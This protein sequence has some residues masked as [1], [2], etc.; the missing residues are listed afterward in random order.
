[1]VAAQGDMTRFVLD[2][3]TMWQVNKRALGFPTEPRMVF[4]ARAMRAFAA[5]HF[6]L[7]VHCCADNLPAT[8]DASASPSQQPEARPSAPSSS[9]RT[10]TIG[11]Q[12]VVVIPSGG[13]ASG[14]G[15]FLD[16]SCS[17]ESPTY[18]QYLSSLRK[19][20]PTLRGVTEAKM[21]VQVHADGGKYYAY[22]PCGRQEIAVWIADNRQLVVKH[23]EEQEYALDGASFTQEGF[24]LSISP[25]SIRQPRHP[26]WVPTRGDVK[27]QVVGHA[28]TVYKVD[29]WGRFS[30]LAV[31]V[32]EIA[33]L[34]LVVNHCR[35]GKRRDLAWQL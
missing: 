33:Q 4:S 30:L 28:P 16:E 32:E 22:Q 23:W 7:L 12:T 27:G 18:R 21:L 15:F 31:A 17:P 35:Q 29:L 25:G 9:A 8:L 26:D 34:P 24:T 14:D 6:A 20:A 2:G 19:G 1:M 3:V 11:E 5:I 13:S 10:V